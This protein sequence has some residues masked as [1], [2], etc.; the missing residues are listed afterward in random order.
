MATM[1]PGFIRVREIGQIDDRTL[2][3][4]WT[5]GR[6]DTFDV[7]ALRRLCPCAM[8]IDEWTGVK[9]LDPKAVPETVRPVQIDSVGSYAMQIRFTDGH[10]TGIYTFQMLRDMAHPKH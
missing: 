2:A 7:V 8:C 3:V 9:R 4:S 5:D 6:K 10:G 1:E